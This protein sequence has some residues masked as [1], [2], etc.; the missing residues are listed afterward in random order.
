MGFNRDNLRVDNE[1]TNSNWIHDACITC[2]VAHVCETLQIGGLASLQCNSADIG[3]H[4]TNG[5][6]WHVV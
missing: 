4:G 3:I 5:R 2:L 1:Y 6:Q